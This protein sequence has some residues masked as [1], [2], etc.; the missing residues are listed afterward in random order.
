ML[1]KHQGGPDLE[2]GVPGKGPPATLHPQ[3]Q[4]VTGNN[5]FHKEDFF[6]FLPPEGNARTLG[7][8]MMTT[9]TI[10]KKKKSLPRSQWY[11]NNFY[12]LL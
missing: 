9:V 4:W 3:T 8:C 11:K 7:L 6:F 10:R 5:P 1:C 12:L 2:L